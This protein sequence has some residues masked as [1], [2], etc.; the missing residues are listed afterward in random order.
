MHRE[1]PTNN[2]YTYR[3]GTKLSGVVLIQ[4]PVINVKKFRNFKKYWILRAQTSK[5]K[6][7]IIKF[8][9]WKNGIYYWQKLL[10]YNGEVRFSSIRWNYA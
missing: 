5:Y 1:E 3:K 10:Q 9:I 4:P 2:L 6:K 8:P 7:T